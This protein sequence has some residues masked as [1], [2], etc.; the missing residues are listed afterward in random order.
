M[1]EV[2][3]NLSKEFWGSFETKAEAME[4]IRKSLVEI[5]EMRISECTDEEELSDLSADLA[6]LDKGNF[7]ISGNRYCDFEILEA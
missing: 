6:D 1:F 7:S 2:Y 5:V 3:D 4:A